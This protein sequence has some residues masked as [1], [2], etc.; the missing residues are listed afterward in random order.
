MI[1]GITGYGYYDQLSIPIIEN[2]AHEHELSQS[3]GEAIA[4]NPKACAV[5]VRRHGMYVWGDNW[6]QAKRHG[7]CLHYLFEIALNM[8]K[9]GMDFNTPPLESSP[10]SLINTKKR[11]NEFSEINNKKG[12]INNVSNKYK[13]VVFDIEG[14]TTPITFVKDVLFPYSSSHVESYLEENWENPQ[15]REI[16]VDLLL[17]R[18]KDSSNNTFIHP[19]INHIN[20]L[21]KNNIDEYIECLVNYIQW[22]IIKD[23]KISPLKKLQGKIW[24]QGY[25]NGDLKSIIFD[26]VLPYFSNLKDNGINISIYSS[27]SKEAQQL[28]FKHSNQGDMRSLIS[29][30]FDT[31]IGNK[32]EINSYK[33][34]CLTL[35]VDNPSEILFLTDIVQEAQAATEAGI[36][37]IVSIRDGNT[38]LPNKHNFKTVT[39]FKELQF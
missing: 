14:T 23:N 33:E 2:T 7:E 11:N 17:Q 31:K 24:Q 18:Q 38:A 4:K 36:D 21:N 25:S 32:R 22:N 39:N 29:C 19:H 1:K 5:L 10:V 27:G 34:I 26:D 6:E 3:L 13:H 15:T 12:Y 16:V 8:K 30:Y 20:S 28:L 37:C 9:L 35:G